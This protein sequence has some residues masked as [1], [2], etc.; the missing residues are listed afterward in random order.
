MIKHADGLSF[1]ECLK[2]SCWPSNRATG[3][4]TLK[5]LYN[6]VRCLA[7]VTHKYFI[8]SKLPPVKY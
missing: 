3:S 5:K 7:D 4:V 2:G 6:E 1:F 8:Y